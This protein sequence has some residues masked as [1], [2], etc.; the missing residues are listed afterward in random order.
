MLYRQLHAAIAVMLDEEI[1][2]NLC[3]IRGPPFTA[4]RL[5]TEDCTAG[6]RVLLVPRTPALGDETWGL[7]L[8]N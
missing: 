8:H 4:S 5:P 2:H 3:V 1:P 6:I 7:P